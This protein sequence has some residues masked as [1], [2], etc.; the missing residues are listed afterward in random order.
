MREYRKRKRV[1][2]AGA[3]TSLPAA[4][5]VVRAPEL[6]ESLKT[7]GHQT[8]PRTP[9]PYENLFAAASKPRWN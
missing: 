5:F 2:K 1:G 8:A 6:R 3:P 7:T 4:F 9:C